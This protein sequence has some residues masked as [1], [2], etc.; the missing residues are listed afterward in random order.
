MGFPRQY[1][2]EYLEIK[3][4]HISMR[5]QDQV[6]NDHK[7]FILLEGMMFFYKGVCIP[8]AKK[9]RLTFPTIFMLFFLKRNAF[10]TLLL[11]PVVVLF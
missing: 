4:K 3:I 9:E 6:L 8:N 7:L 5:F 11:Q 10:H 1:I 2:A